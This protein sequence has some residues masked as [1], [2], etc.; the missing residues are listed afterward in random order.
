M[1]YLDLAVIF[2]YLVGITWFG[3]RFRHSQKT[4]R[5]YFLGG[6]SAPWWAICFSIVSTETSTLTIIGTPALAFTGNLGFLQVV[7]GYLLGRI[8][9]VLLFLPHYFRGEMYTAYELMEVRF[10]ER[11]RKLTAGLFLVLRALAEAVRVFAVAIVISVVFGTG[12]V[13]SIFLILCLTLLYVSQGGMKAVIWTD[14]IQMILYV[15]GGL[16]SLVFIVGLIDGGWGEL[17]RVAGADGKLRIFDFGFSPTAEFFEQTYT[18]WAGLIGGAFL[19]TA[20]HGT[21]QLLVQR[22]LAARCEADSRKALL[23]SWVI[24][25]LQFALF[26][27]VG[28]A[29]YVYYQQKELPPPETSDRLYPEFIWQQLPEGIAGL[30]VAAILAAAMSTLSSSLSSLSSTTVVDFWLPLRRRVAGE[31]SE[32]ATLK[33][34][35]L[36]TL[37][38]GAVLFGV[39]LLAR[40][41][42]SVLEAG[43]SVASVLYGS[44]L[45]VFLLGILPRR[46]GETAGIAGMIAGFATMAFVKFGTSIAWTWYVV[47]G[48]TATFAVGYAFSVLHSG[49]LDD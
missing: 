10:S 42:G 40:H 45:G 32:E 29:L 21:E 35:R 48:T 27:V 8:L 28:L 19:A 26:L 14:V 7:L 49:R 25:M 43:L 37:V 41:W 15:A 1:R 34:G 22:L 39:G 30:L 46:V 3:A 5:D 13:V 9:I 18:F 36:I 47:I 12:E 24:I 2:A 4:L 44:L 16:I 20:S 23:V 38:W 11:L 6:R 33:L 17:L 31:L